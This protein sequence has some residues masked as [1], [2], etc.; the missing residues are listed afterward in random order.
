M[1]WMY[2]AK[3]T[4]SIIAMAEFLSQEP[5]GRGLEDQV[6]EMVQAVL[7][8]FCHPLPKFVWCSRLSPAEKKQ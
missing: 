4:A 5:N 8:L 7:Q 1:Q 2:K 3:L 6:E